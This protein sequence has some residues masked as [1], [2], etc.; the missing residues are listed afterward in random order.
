MNI[1]ILNMNIVVSFSFVENKNFKCVPLDWSQGHP[2]FPVWSSPRIKMKMKAFDFQN[3]INKKDYVGALAILEHGHCDNL[4]TVD[5]LLWVAYCASRV[6]HYSRAKEAYLKLLSSEHDDVPAEVGLYLAISHFYLGSYH[7]AQQAA[8]SFAGDSELKNRILLH[9]ARATDDETSIAKY[10][11]HLSDS[12]QDQLSAAAIELYRCRYKK[13]AEHLE[14][15]I[16]NDDLALNVYLAIC[17]FKMVRAFTPMKTFHCTMLPRSHTFTFIVH[18][19]V[20]I[21]PSR[22]LIYIPMLSQAASSQP[23]SRLATYFVF[24]R[25]EK[26][27]STSLKPVVMGRR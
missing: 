9:I 2:S 12:K 25:T 7:D 14:K 22:C 27:L 5:R 13:T 19:I 8:L 3:Y 26:L 10:R 1:R 24:V 16:A 6:G 21:C 15:I 4:S 23:T 17:Y 20:S 18:R 11:Q